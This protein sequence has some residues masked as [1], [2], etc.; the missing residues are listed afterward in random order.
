MKSELLFI[1][2]LQNNDSDKD[3]GDAADAEK[4]FLL[5]RLLGFN[6]YDTSGGLP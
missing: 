1:H 6:V 3:L 4:M 5:D 2:Q